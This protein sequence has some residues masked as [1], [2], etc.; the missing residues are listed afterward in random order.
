ML[1]ALV[2]GLGQNVA[3]GQNLAP[4]VDEM[5][6]RVSFAQQGEH[7]IFASAA[8]ERDLFVNT[9]LFYQNFSPQGEWRVMGMPGETWELN[10]DTNSIYA[11]K[12][13][14][15]GI[16]EQDNFPILSVEWNKNVCVVG[17]KVV[18]ARTIREDGSIYLQLYA[19]NTSDI[20]L[21]AGIDGGGAVELQPNSG[22]PFEFFEDASGTLVF[23]VKEGGATCATVKFRSPE[24]EVDPIEDLCPFLIGK[25]PQAQFYGYVYRWTGTRVEKGSVVSATIASGEV[26]GCQ[27]TKEDGLMPF[28]PIFPDPGV[29]SPI[30]FFVNGKSVR[31]EPV[32]NSWQALNG[33]EQFVE[34]HEMAP[35]P[36]ATPSATPT[37]TPTPTSTPTPTATPTVTPTVT[38]TATATPTNTPTPT[39]TPTATSTATPTATPTNTPTATPSATPTPWQ[40]FLPTLGGGGVLPPDGGA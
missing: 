13:I 14:E 2:L 23:F 31:S 35:T 11:V 4:I 21:Y 29:D 27:I 9:T 40:V 39:A 33:G 5:Q 15:F 30:T 16:R 19:I 6:I 22:M 7:E 37:Q 1:F 17:P 24:D 18:Y 34:L 3:Q 10:A 28:M 20:P 8:P 38:P 36:T 25:I 32:V 12:K 26:V